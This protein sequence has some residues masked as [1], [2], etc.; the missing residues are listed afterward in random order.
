MVVILG[1]IAIVDKLVQPENALVPIIMMM[2]M[3]MMIMM[4]IIMMIMMILMLI[5]A[6]VV[7]IR[8]ISDTY[9]RNSSWYCN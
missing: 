7:M 2:L 4:I 1:G 5:T 3:L 6:V 9:R 8:V